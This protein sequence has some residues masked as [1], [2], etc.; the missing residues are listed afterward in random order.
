MI[1]CNAMRRCQ[2]VK[3]EENKIVKPTTFPI[4]SRSQSLTS[5]SFEACF[6]CTGNAV[7]QGGRNYEVFHITHSLLCADENLA[8]LSSPNLAS[9]KLG[10]MWSEWYKDEADVAAFWST[11]IT[12]AGTFTHPFL[13]AHCFSLIRYPLPYLR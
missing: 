2:C 6:H 8:V 12:N 13:I 3:D 4:L 7:N 1:R 11:R 5:L 10:G 9:L